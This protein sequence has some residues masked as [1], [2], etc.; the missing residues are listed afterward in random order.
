MQFTKNKL[1]LA[2]LVALTP[3]AYAEDS[4]N[5]DTIDVVSDNISPQIANV[6]AKGA[7]KVRQP[8]KMSD[9]LRGI[10]G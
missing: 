2:M 3:L 8:T 7:V 5:L 6:S 1:S 10:P 4:I 9:V